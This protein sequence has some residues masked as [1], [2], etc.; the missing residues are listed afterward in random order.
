[1][2]VACAPSFPTLLPRRAGGEG[3]QGSESVNLGPLCGVSPAAYPCGVSPVAYPE[4]DDESDAEMWALYYVD[5]SFSSALDLID[6]A[7]L[8]IDRAHVD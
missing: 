8:T 4:P 7:L 2:W 6:S 1:M 5:D 3:S